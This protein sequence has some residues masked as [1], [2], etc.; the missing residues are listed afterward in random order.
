MRRPIPKK[1]KN[2]APA[3]AILAPIGHNGLPKEYVATAD[4][5]IPADDPWL[6]KRQNMRAA[7]RIV[8]KF[9]PQQDVVVDENNTVL[10]G[11]S[12]VIG[13]LGAGI[14]MLPVRR[15]ADLSLAEKKA[16]SIGYSKLGSLGG[17][18]R[19]RLGN[20]LR[21][22]I[23]EDPD[24]DIEDLGLTI[25]EA[26]QALVVIDDDGCETV[27]AP[28]ASAVT[29]VGDVYKLGRHRIMCGDA[30]DSDAYRQLMIGLRAAMVITDPPYGCRIENF[31]SP[32]ARHREF[33]H[34]SDG[35][36][37]EELFTLFERSLALVKIHSKEGALIY[38][39]MDWRSLNLLLNAATPL[40]GKLFN[41]AVWAKDRAGMGSFLR[42]R[43]ELIP[44]FRAPG[45]KH[46][47]NVE[48]G[49]H[50]RDRSNVWEYPSAKTFGKGS[51]EGDMLANHPTPKP[52]QMIA[53]AMLDCSRRGDV[54]LDVF[55][56]SGTT[57][58]AAEKT[59]RVCYC[60]EL[61]PLYVELAVRRWQTWTGE[62]AIHEA[63][64]QS[65]DQYV[66][67]QMEAQNG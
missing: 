43:H 53:D 16:L 60:M 21:E 48:L 36:S 44:I 51:D 7:T 14:A 23:I 47:N 10:I 42:S 66:R 40:F 55:S 62:K 5:K 32:T 64:G 49:R 28:R 57:I 18:E 30:T 22:I 26:D 27:P 33:V 52:V 67:E 39:F 19:A 58:I 11:Q 29:K 8:K 6:L 41:M 1:P 31:A 46:L 35:I 38:V 4:F 9:G 54:V 25:S 12:I 34:G 45:G 37:D 2:A 59:G 15:L 56:G 20:W 65:F 3:N 61:D 17:F 13:A 50:G 24:F 63:T